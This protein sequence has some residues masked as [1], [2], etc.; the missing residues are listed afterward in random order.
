[1][2]WFK[3]KD[4]MIAKNTPPEGRQV[5]TES[6]LTKCENED[7]QRRGLKPRHTC[8]VLLFQSANDRVFNSE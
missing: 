8:R 7:G 1:M 5:K 3:S 2:P 6:I 4:G